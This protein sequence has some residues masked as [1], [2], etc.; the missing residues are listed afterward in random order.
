M[1]IY[2]GQLQ[3]YLPHLGEFCHE[4]VLT[5]LDDTHNPIG[6]IH[7][8][9]CANSRLERTSHFLR[10]V[11]N[12]WFTSRQTRTQCES[13]CSLTM[14]Q[15]QNLSTCINCTNLAANFQCAK[16]ATEVGLSSSCSDHSYK[17][18]LNKQSSCDNCS[19]FQSESCPNPTKAAIGMLC[20]AWTS[21]TI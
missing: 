18:S 6:L 13:I 16:H 17:V 5:Q 8:P 4:N 20:F 2:R 3:L 7:A 15:I 11:L 10:I 9:I 14:T 21:Q 1:Q 12:Q 19:N